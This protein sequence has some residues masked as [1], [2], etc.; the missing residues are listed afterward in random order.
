MTDREKL[1][2]KIRALTAKTVAAGCTEAE[3]MAA[4]EKVAALMRDH[5]VSETVIDM[6]KASIGVKFDVRSIKTRVCT[7]VAHVTNSAMVHLREGRDKTVIYVGAAPGPQIACYLH[8]VLHRA[9][10]GGVKEFRKGA[11]YKARRSDKTRRK[12]VEDFVDGMIRS[13]VCRLLLMF[14]ANISTARGDQARAALDEMFPKARMVRPKEA[15]ARFADATYAGDRA[16]A[17]VNFRHGV[18]RGGVAGL[19]GKAGA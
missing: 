16:G 18:E 17:R 5:A 14:R 2:A 19:I 6:E 9:I 3:A 11:F 13:L 1:I 4:A 8:D 10:E 15:K 12:A 7:A